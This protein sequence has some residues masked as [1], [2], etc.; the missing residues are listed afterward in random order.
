MRISNLHY[1]IDLQFIAYEATT[2]QF[3]YVLK[4]GLRMKFKKNNPLLRYN[5]ILALTV[6]EE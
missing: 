6:E 5:T 4:Y 2:W 3:Y 1:R